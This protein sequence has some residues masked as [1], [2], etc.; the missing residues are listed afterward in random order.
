VNALLLT[1]LL[2][3]PAELSRDDALTSIR[4]YLDENLDD[5]NYSIVK[6]WEALAADGCLTWQPPADNLPDRARFQL[7]PPWKSLE[8]EGHAVRVK[9]RAKNRLGALVLHEDFFL[10]EDGEVAERYAAI[11]FRLP[12]EDL[13]DYAKRTG[14]KFIPSGADSPLGRFLDDVSSGQNVADELRDKAAEKP[15]R[16]K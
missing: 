10:I 1:L 8:S 5:P 6:Q 2:A 4:T 15:R 7:A 3:G 16:R 13:K 14:Q 12:G 9:Y 11:D